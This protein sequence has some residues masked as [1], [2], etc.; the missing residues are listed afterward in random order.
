MKVD[1]VLQGGIGAYRNSSSVPL[2]KAVAKASSEVMGRKSEYVLSGASIPI[3]AEFVR[4]LGVPTIGMG[5]GLPSDNIH[6]PN[7]HFDMHRFEK[8]FLTV[9]RTIALL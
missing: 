6:A 3:A 8:G 4:V 9:A 2:A 1:V 7:E 5:Y